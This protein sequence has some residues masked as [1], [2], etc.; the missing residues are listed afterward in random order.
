[1]D[2]VT[3]GLVLVIAGFAIV[4]VSMLWGGEGRTEVK[5]GG[6]LMIGPI[7]VI[8]GSDAKW[9]SVAIVLAIVL[10]LVY[11]LGAVL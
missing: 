3:A 2:L 1:M 8:F 9:A 4:V 10:I 6:V 7:P 11:L 5:G